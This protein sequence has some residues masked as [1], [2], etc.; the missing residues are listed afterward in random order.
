MSGWREREMACCV[1]LCALMC[2][3]TP[4]KQKQQARSFH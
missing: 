4:P 2:P 1:G 3:L